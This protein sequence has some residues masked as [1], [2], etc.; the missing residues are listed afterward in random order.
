MF[1]SDGSKGSGL[2]AIDEKVAQDQQGLLQDEVQFYPC[3]CLET[4]RLRC[5]GESCESRRRRPWSRPFMVVVAA[6][7]ALSF[8]VMGA[9]FCSLIT[10]LPSHRPHYSGESCKESLSVPPW[11]PPESKYFSFLFLIPPPWTSVT[12]CEQLASARHSSLTASSD[13]RQ[14]RRTS[15]PGAI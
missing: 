6:L 4:H 13:V 3:A 11:F 12:E 9:G 7:F 1:G 10:G 2:P 8:M 15:K 5:S 14:T